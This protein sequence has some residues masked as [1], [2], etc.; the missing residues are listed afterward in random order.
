MSTP[1]HSTLEVDPNPLHYGSSGLELQKPLP[2]EQ[3]LY[4]VEYE[5]TTYTAN[6]QNAAHEMR[7]QDQI[8]GMQRRM[9]YM[10][11]II[12]VL[13][14]IGAIVGGVVG[15]RRGRG[16]Q[17]EMTNP[18]FNILPASIL[19]ASNLTTWFQVDSRIPRESDSR[20]CGLPNLGIPRLGGLTVVYK[21]LQLFRV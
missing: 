10:I 18:T 3:Y 8:C 14:V 15:R 21:Q 6:N 19:A 9:V 2:E 20:Q 1:P 5:H 17:D 11:A 4:P 12:A 16:Q 13:V 7:K